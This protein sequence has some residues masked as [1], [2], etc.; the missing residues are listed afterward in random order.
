MRHVMADD[1]FQMGMGENEVGPFAPPPPNR[2]FIA[3]K[4]L[5]KTLVKLYTQSKNIDAVPN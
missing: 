5:K 2:Y 1:F 4:N 3:L